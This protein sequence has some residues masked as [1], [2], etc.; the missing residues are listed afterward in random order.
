VTGFLRAKDIVDVENVVAVLVVVA[1]V[2]DALARLGQD[3]ARVSRRLVF[4]ARIAD[5]IGGGEVDGQSLEGADEAT[6]RVGAPEGR[7]SIDLGSKV[8]NSSQ[9]PEF[10]DR[11]TS[12]GQGRRHRSTRR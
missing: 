12:D 6:F 8:G 9:L 5:A 4:E 7:L 2:L 1:I 11:T 3:S 10:G